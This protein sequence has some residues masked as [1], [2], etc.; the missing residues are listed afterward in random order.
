MLNYEGAKKGLKNMV[1]DNWTESELDIVAAELKQRFPAKRYGNFYALEFTPNEVEEAAESVLPHHRHKSVSDYHD[2]RRP[3]FDAFTRIVQPPGKRPALSIVQGKFDAE[4]RITWSPQEWEAVILEL[5]RVCPQAFA[6][7]LK[8]VNIGAVR[9]AMEVLEI[10]RR[11]HFKQIV[12]FKETALKLWDAL[13]IEVRD[14]SKAERQIIEFTSGP[15]MAPPITSKMK[16]NPMAAALQKAF[17]EPQKPVAEIKAV[18]TTRKPN[19]K[20][21]SW[22][23]GDWLKIAREML[24]Q[25]PFGNLLTSTFP[26]ID[27][28]AIKAAQRNVFTWEHHK[29]LKNPYGVREP[30]LEAFATLKQEIQDRAASGTTDEQE[31]PAPS[32]TEIPMSPAD[33]AKQNRIKSLMKANA[34]RAKLSPEERRATAIKGHATRLANKAKNA[35]PNEIEQP[36]V[37]S[38]TPPTVEENPV[39]VAPQDT[40]RVFVP[41]SSN[42]M[43]FFGKVLNAAVPLMNVLIDEA[44]L[45]LAPSLISGLLPQLEK[46]LGGMLHTAIAS[47]M[48]KMEAYLRRQTAPYSGPVGPVSL[49]ASE[50]VLTVSNTVQN[51]PEQSPQLSKTE[52]AALFPQPAQKPKKAKIALLMPMGQQREYVRSAFPEYEFMFID[53][54]QGIK[55][56]GANCALFVAVEAYVTGPNQ[57]SIKAHVPPEKLKY[58]PG[59]L[60]S[61]KRQIN[62]WK[63]QQTG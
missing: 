50:P 26:R 57:K 31:N 35:K 10:P 22:T 41:S 17:S 30:L 38:I 37:V 13:P 8:N 33:T 23:R 32:S 59:G 51:A 48:P 54:G 49:P 60:S 42:E 52:L 24:R 11:R 19:K 40:G 46:S 3:M 61:I 9:I 36:P 7:G 4:G 6:E 53:H 45:R 63:V 25:D 58:V 27:L 18:V 34:A 29:A 20:R 62:V 21:V 12:S 39:A 56:A 16:E 55:E 28:G 43:D 2:I 47:Q 15:V 14:P 1:I 5:D 44:V